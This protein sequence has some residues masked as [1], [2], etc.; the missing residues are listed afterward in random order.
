MKLFLDAYL[1]QMRLAYSPLSVSVDII[2]WD[3]CDSWQ[4]FLTIHR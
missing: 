3:L 2:S 1:N 4:I